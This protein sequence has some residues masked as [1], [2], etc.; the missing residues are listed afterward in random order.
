MPQGGGQRAGAAVVQQPR[1]V[2]EESIVGDGLGEDIEPVLSALPMCLL[3]LPLL[4][5]LPPN[6]V[7][8]LLPLL[9]LLL[10]SLT[11]LLRFLFVLLLLLVAGCDQRLPAASEHHKR[12]LELPRCCCQCGCQQ[13]RL[14][15]QSQPTHRAEINT[16]RLW[17]PFLPLLVAGCLGQLAQGTRQFLL[18]S[19]KAVAAVPEAAEVHRVRPVAG[20]LDEELTEA[21]RGQKELR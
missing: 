1:T 11:R 16:H 2:G 4:L 5:L 8:G 12:A 19:R 14:P 15:D 6:L 7:L 20:L 3:L 10:P 18:G 13:G 21:C 17:L 9:L